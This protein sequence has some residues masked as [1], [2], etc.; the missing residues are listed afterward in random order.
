M[1]AHWDLLVTDEFP[2][3]M[4]LV[5]QRKVKME[6]LDSFSMEDLEGR[7]NINHMKQQTYNPE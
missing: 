6:V 4:D 2:L 3:Y 1:E 7:N 5:L